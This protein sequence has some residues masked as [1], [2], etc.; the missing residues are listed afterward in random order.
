[1]K[2]IAFFTDGWNRLITYVWNI[3]ID[4]ALTEYDEPVCVHQFNCFG[5]WSRDNK[6]N[7]GEYNI[8]QLPDLSEYDGILMDLTNITDDTVLSMLLNKVRKTKI[9]AISLGKKF[10]GFYFVGIDNSHTVSHLMEHVYYV[11]DC[12]SFIFAGGPR[13]NWDNREREQTYRDFLRE[14]GLSIDKNPV[15][16]G[17]YTFDCGIR[18]FEEFVKTG[19]KMPDAFICGNDNIASGI[20]V[21]AKDHGYEVPRDF[22][23]TG[24][25][26]IEQSKY[27][28]PHLT[29]VEQKREKISA[30]AMHMLFDIWADKEP[31]QTVLVDNLCV[32]SQSCGCVV[33]DETDYTYYVGQLV[34]GNSKKYKLEDELAYYQNE[35]TAANSFQEI[36]DITKNYVL[37]Q[38]CTGFAALIDKRLLNLGSM[39]QFQ[40]MGYE[41]DQLTV[42]VN[43]RDN[44]VIY[45][46]TVDELYQ[47]IYGEEE[48]AHYLFSPIHYQEKNLGYVT[49]KN[50]NFFFDNPYFCNMLI[51]FTQAL[52]R[53][54]HSLALERENDKLDY[55]HKHDQLTGVYNRIALRMMA[56]KYIFYLHEAGI[57]CVVLFADADN[58]KKINDTYGHDKGDE[59]LTKI[60]QTMQNN[61][62]KNG[63][64]FRYGGDEFVALFAL[65]SEGSDE[66]YNNKVESE[67]KKSDISV[68]IGKI[69]T[70]PS[71]KVDLNELL[72]LADMKMYEIKRDR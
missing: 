29:T 53:I 1:M 30:A 9:P 52:V 45:E 12:R 23:V 51:Y 48:S 37:G 70:S 14:K 50:G 62:P 63:N 10:D 3:G 28:R 22:I 46:T 61:L 57:P 33:E 32:F 58:F 13:D 47:Q 21:A 39:E 42:A 25:D 55:L 56:E 6:Y 49:M 71:Q 27:F 38:E 64:V 69:I 7:I 4:Q 16:Y 41:M 17:D 34:T 36:F 44:R 68:S 26:N 35:L 60:A 24:F 54:Y 2:K 59:V 65:S 43:V 8:F 40:N 20:I 18:Y 15:W 5:N 67:L 66:K 31:G 11:H 72:K 19:I